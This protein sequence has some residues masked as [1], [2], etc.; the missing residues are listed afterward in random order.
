MNKHDSK[1]SDNLELM[2]KEEI[3]LK[4]RITEM[5]WG[6]LFVNL[7][8][9]EYY[10]V[11]LQIFYGD[12][13]PLSNK[14]MIPL[15]H[16]RERP[17]PEGGLSWIFMQIPMEALLTRDLAMVIEVHKVVKK[18]GDVEPM[19]CFGI[20]KNISPIKTLEGWSIINL[21][22]SYLLSNLMAG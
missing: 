16:N 10:E 8:V 17:A 7:D 22:A 20:T 5:N 14:T 18:Y 2:L 13:K 6:S 1:R 9:D 21:S 15:V 19:R 11:S 3:F 4:F 12:N